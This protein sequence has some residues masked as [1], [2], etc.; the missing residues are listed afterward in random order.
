MPEEG[1]PEGESSDP[2]EGGAG[3]QPKPEEHVHR[4]HLEKVI[5][6][7][8]RAKSA[9]R[10]T[11]SQLASLREAAG[12]GIELTA[13]S[14]K[15]FAAWK[16]EQQVAERTAA[17]KKGEFDSILA[18]ERSEH[19]KQLKAK[20]RANAETMDHLRSEKLGSLAG[21]QLLKTGVTPEAAKMAKAQM[22]AEGVDGIKMELVLEGGKYVPQ[23]RDS[24]GVWPGDGEGG[25][26]SFDAFAQKF[27]DA[28]PFLYRPQVEAGAGGVGPGATRTGGL[29]PGQP[30]TLSSALKGDFDSYMKLVHPEK[31]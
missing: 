17:E 1:K 8:D 21:E 23:L 22:L 7:R 16:K 12:D 9:A 29:Q 11:E 10:E 6:E 20:E 4:S 14:V 5:S 18:K 30:V 19:S 27:K 3:K 24:N 31:G 25:E 15:E 26:L 2:P 28:N 13:D